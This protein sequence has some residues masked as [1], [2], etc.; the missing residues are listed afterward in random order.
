MVTV[1][2]LVATASLRARAQGQ[3]AACCGEPLRLPRRPRTPENPPTSTIRART[4]LSNLLQD[5]GR[6]REAERME[7]ETLAGYLQERAQAEA[8]DLLEAA[9]RN[10]LEPN[11]RRDVS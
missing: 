1:K 8:L 11:L 2:S 6:S 3:L 10:G 7:R 5:R 9:V 4:S